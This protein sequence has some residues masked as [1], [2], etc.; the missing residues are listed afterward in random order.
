[1]KQETLPMEEMFVPRR[2]SK[3]TKTN[4]QTYEGF[5]YN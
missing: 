5:F 1:M 2:L 3:D 4:K